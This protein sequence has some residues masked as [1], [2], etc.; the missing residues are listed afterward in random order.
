M[1]ATKLPTERRPSHEAEMAGIDAL[2][3]PVPPHPGRLA[4]FWK[5]SWPKIA[6]AALLIAVWQLVV[7]SGW[8]PSYVLP[9]PDKVLPRISRDLASGKLVSAAATTLSRAALGF[10]I[11]LVLGV[12]LGIAV[13][14]SSYVRRA[15]GALIT[16][17]QT[18]PSIAWF[19]L[20]ILLFKL[21]ET[22]ILF[23]VVLGAAPAIANG[24]VAGIDHIPRVLL[25]AG[26]VLGARG[27]TRYRHVVLPAA[28]PSF[29]SGLKQGW[30]FAWR[31]LMAGELIVIIANRPSLGVGLQLAREISDAEGLLAIMIVILFIGLFVDMAVFGPLDRAVRTRWGLM[32][33]RR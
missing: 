14:T 5:S 7:L 26:S 28:T 13:S 10:G 18:M 6:A 20:A 22:A 19:P 27:F 3:I 1:R 11:A 25:R 23:V 9:G 4:E 30:A 33:V 16:G 2:E 12:L 32:E 21:S 15:V 24:I 17:F 29:I 8:K 31:S